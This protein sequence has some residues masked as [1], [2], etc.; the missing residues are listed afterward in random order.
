M[1]ESCG[2][3][4]L[5]KLC[6]LDNFCYLVYFIVKKEVTRVSV[7]ISKVYFPSLVKVDWEDLSSIY[8][9]HK[10]G[11]VACLQNNIPQFSIYNITIHKRLT[12]WKHTTICNPLK[13]PMNIYNILI[14]PSCSV[15][16]MR[17]LNDK[18]FRTKTVLCCFE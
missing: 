1:K 12:T 16:L 14:I 18:I 3:R 15:T 10:E 7:F 8:W 2:N 11:T 17:L 5:S 4:I 13:G 6:K 9:L